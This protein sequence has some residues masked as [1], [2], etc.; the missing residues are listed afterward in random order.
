VSIPFPDT[1]ELLPLEEGVVDFGVSFMPPRGYVGFLH[2]SEECNA[3]TS[4]RLITTVGRSSCQGAIPL[5][6][7]NFCSF[8]PQPHTSSGSRCG[9]TTAHLP[10]PPLWRRANDTSACTW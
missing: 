6:L 7:K 5:H 2:L 9:Y 4:L 8:I 3:Q 1:Y 10:E